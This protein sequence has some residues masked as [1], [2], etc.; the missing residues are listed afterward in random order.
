MSLQL[1]MLLG[2]K[3]RYRAHLHVLKDSS[4]TDTYSEKFSLT[5]ESSAASAAI[6]PKQSKPLPSQ[7]KLFQKM[8][9]AT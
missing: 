1:L 3:M 6:A 7:P 4:E 2:L 8:H 5:S 9:S